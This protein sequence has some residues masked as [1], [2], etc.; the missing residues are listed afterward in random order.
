MEDTREHDVVLQPKKVSG[1]S[2]LSWG[3]GIPGHY[4][5]QNIHPSP[6]LLHYCL[7]LFVVECQVRPLTYCLKLPNIMKKLH[8]VFNIVKLSTAPE[9]LILERKLK[10]LPLPIVIDR[11]EK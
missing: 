8:P 5:Y 1:P 11:E 2:V 7:G 9:D 4:Q 10:P 3:L 6:K